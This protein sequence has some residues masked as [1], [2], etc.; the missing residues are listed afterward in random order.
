MYVHVRNL[1]CSVSYLFDSKPIKSAMSLNL[2]S[3]SDKS[4]SFRLPRF[5]VPRFAMVDLPLEKQNG[6]HEARGIVFSLVRDS[7]D[8]KARP[9]KV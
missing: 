4:Q 5:A 9:F 2:V 8:R 7:P 6:W 1:Y 3:H